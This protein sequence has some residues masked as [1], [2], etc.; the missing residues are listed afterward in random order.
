MELTGKVALVTGGAH[1]LGRAIALALGTAGCHIALH[2]HQSVELAQAT[3]ADLAALGVE[4]LAVPGDLTQVAEAEQVVD[5]AAA[6]W[7]RLDLLVCSAGIWGRTPLGTVTETEWDRLYDLNVRSA[8]FMAQRA[9]PH[10]RAVAGCIIAIADVGI[11]TTWKHYTPYLS[12]KA[13]LAMLMQNLARDLAP[14]VRVNT[15]APG[16]VL[17]PAD[18]TAAQ[19]ARLA[20]KTL[21]GRVGTPDDIADAVLYLARAAYVTGVMLPVDGGYRL[22]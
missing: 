22:K 3:L 8:F 6:H 10:L 18:W 4:T 20:E 21:L 5:T 14:E 12:S 19:H 16:A 17:L 11:T 1:R 9:A 2:Y 15:I 13:A 7:G